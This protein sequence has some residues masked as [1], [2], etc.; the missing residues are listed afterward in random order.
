M[1]DPTQ[2]P[3]TRPG[4]TL[5]FAHVTDPHLTSPDQPSL[6]SLL[7]KRF[8][9]YLS[10][11]R[12]RCQIHDRG[13]LDMLVD[14]LRAS[15]AQHLA[16]T[17]DLTQL[18]LDSEFQDALEWLRE[19]SAPGRVSLI[20]G[21]HD[22]L[23]ADDWQRT[24]HR[25]HEFM[26]SDDTSLDHPSDFPTSRIRGPVVFIGLSSAVPTAPFLATGSLGAQQRQRLGEMLD[27]AREGGLFRV[28][29]IHHP[30]IPGRYKWRKRL[31]DSRAT[32]DVIRQ[33]GAELVL[34]GH[35]HR[36]TGTSLEGTDGR[37]I[38][39]I[40]LSS[41]SAGEVSPERA[42]RY[43][44]WTVTRTGD[45]FQLQHRSRVYDASSHRIREGHDWNPLHDQ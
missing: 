35:T 15:T 41:A 23:V 42:A 29:L 33:S 24:L 10:W 28:V 32:S 9:S 6:R 21:N 3:D 20:P 39:I 31:V 4:D 34:H 14:D 26:A 37:R 18:G 44:L 38:P 40:G 12:H 8:L 13:V 22:C 45:C 16:I 30:P 25:W 7:N 1:P 27:T 5:T 17:G 43:S 2:N 19:L 11:R 36:L